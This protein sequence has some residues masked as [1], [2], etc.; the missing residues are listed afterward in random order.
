M[1][2]LVRQIKSANYRHP[3]QKQREHVA[4]NQTGGSNSGRSFNP[5]GE[6]GSTGA[7]K[8]RGFT[9]S[10]NTS[11]VKVPLML[12]HELYGLREGEMRVNRR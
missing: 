5:G 4:I 6:G 8:G 3:T 7:S 9:R 10:V 2:R 1:G 12:P 11:P